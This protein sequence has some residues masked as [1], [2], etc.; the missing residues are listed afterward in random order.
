[1]EK[2]VIG[3]V[4]FVLLGCTE[5]EKFTGIEAKRK[6]ELESCICLKDE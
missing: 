2:Y 1:M 5:H 4:T 6:R 3:Y